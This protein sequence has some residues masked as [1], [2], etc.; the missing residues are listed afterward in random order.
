V[1][2]LPSLGV[3]AQWGAN[4]TW[5]TYL[6]APDG[7]VMAKLPGFRI[8][9]LGVAPSRRLHL[10]RDGEAYTLD[11][12]KGVVVADQAAP[13]KS[14]SPNTGLGPTNPRTGEGHYTWWATRSSNLFPVTLPG[15]PILAQWNEQE[16]ECSKPV[17]V[18]TTRPGLAPTPLTGSLRGGPSS[19]ALGW[20]VQGALVSVG[21]GP[22]GQPAGWAPGLY[23]F[24]VGG[25]SSKVPTPQGVYQFRLWGA[26]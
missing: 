6:L 15:N 25:G 20:T 7:K 2:K 1:G 12:G 24:K 16:G 11:P 10:I 22:C 26:S 14:A 3:A 19:V 13:V 21:M 23:L 8:A 4:G 9:D 17:A 5:G 18:I